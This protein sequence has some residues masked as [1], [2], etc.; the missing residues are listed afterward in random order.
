MRPVKNIFEYLP[1][2]ELEPIKEFA[3]D[4]VAPFWIIDLKKIGRKY[5]ELQ[6]NLPFAKIYYAVKAN[7]ATE[8][9][10]LL[11]Q[12]GS[13]FDVAS[14]YEIHQLL[15]LGISPERMS[16]G[17]PIKKDLE[18][19]YA[20]QNGIRLFATDSFG[21]VEAL[22]REA[23]GSRII[24]RLLLD[25]SST[26]DWPLSRKFGCH[27]GMVYDLVVKAKEL[28]LEPYGL[29]F[30][31][32]SQQ[33]DLG[34]WDTALG[35]CSHIFSEL[36]KIGIQ[37]KAIDLGGGLPAK[38]IYPTPDTEEYVEAIKKYLKDEF[39]GDLPEIIIEPGRSITGDSGVMIAEVVNVATKSTHSS[40]PWVFLDVGKFRGLIE[41]IDESIKYPIFVERHLEEPADDYEEMIL[42]GPSCD[43]MDVMYE[44]HKCKLPADI[45]RGDR[46]FILTTGAYTYSYTSVCFNGFPPPPV[47]FI[48]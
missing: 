47:Y 7:P 25:G 30:H 13:N 34:Q 4:K 16:Y 40:I 46:V 36:K 42:A 43:S 26:A 29:C 22:A 24:F 45:K 8:V 28:G 11:G 23:P 12:R 2:K 21:D 27:Q 9:I 15:S 10:Q 32:G 20:Y 6:K 14:V 31:V 3:K 18:I 17:N 1:P 5:D 48:N 41:T 35:Q 37:L 39:N 38:Y 33:R 44:N 19:R